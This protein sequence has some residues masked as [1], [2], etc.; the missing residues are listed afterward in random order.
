MSKLKFLIIGLVISLSGFCQSFEFVIDSF[1]TIKPMDTI[2]TKFIMSLDTSNMIE[3]FKGG[4][5][6]VDSKGTV[7]KEYK[8]QKNH[9]IGK[10]FKDG[11]YWALIVTD[12]TKSGANA[13]RTVQLT[14][15]DTL[16]SIIGGQPIGLYV[17]MMHTFHYKQC[18]FFEYGFKIFTSWESTRFKPFEN[19][20]EIYEIK[21]NS[22]IKTN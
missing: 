12:F 3:I 11:Y 10:F 8:N 2:D 4:L 21:N 17:D 5:K 19:E 18:F 22:L 9:A 20:T 13:S 15:H 6:E 16:G 7:I 1:P 14:I